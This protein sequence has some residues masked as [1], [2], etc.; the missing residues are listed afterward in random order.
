MPG[1][2]GPSSS[3][4]GP[5]PAPHSVPWGSSS[6][7]SPGNFRVWYLPL[8]PFCCL[9]FPVPPPLGQTPLG[10]LHPNHLLSWPLSL[11]GQT[12]PWFSSFKLLLPDYPLPCSCFPGPPA[13]GHL[14]PWI[15]CPGSPPLLPLKPPSLDHLLP[16]ASLPLGNFSPGRFS[17]PE[18]PVPCTSLSF[19]QPPPLSNV[20]WIFSFLCH[21]PGSL[22]ILHIPSHTQSSSRSCSP[23]SQRPSQHHSF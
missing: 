3:S 16:R 12:L 22:P 9:S 11:L 6:P 1:L 23:G 13:L 2:P 18:P 15:T 5:A 20:P 14:L 4:P 10:H 7:P 19:G 21:L 17:F 8:S